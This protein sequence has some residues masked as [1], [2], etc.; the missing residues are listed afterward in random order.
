MP[1]LVPL[2]WGRPHPEHKPPS[3]VFGERHGAHLGV[4]GGARKLRDR[5]ADPR[6]LHDAGHGRQG[7][8]RIAPDLGGPHT[9]RASIIGKDASVGS[10]TMLS[11]VVVGDRAQVGAGI[12]LINGARV[13]PDVVLSDG[14][15]RFSSDA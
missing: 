8:E 11:E 6:P 10:G 15:V 4:P 3:R 1:F 14:S 2:R 12:E 9:V 5:R 13:W 7:D